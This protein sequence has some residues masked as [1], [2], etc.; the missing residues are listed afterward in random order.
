[1]L[2]FFSPLAGLKT[3]EILLSHQTHLQQSNS[4]PQKQHNG[5]LGVM[6]ILQEKNAMME[7]RLQASLASVVLWASSLHVTVFR[8]LSKGNN[9]T[10]HPIAM[11]QRTPLQGINYSD[12]W[13]HSFQVR[14]DGS[15]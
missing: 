11:T 9:F 2:A 14:T 10:A 4:K 7:I 8:S 6:V 12:S 5:H 15:M 13:L 1:L 3:R